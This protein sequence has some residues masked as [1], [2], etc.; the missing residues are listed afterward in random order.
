MHID[1]LRVEEVSP[2]ST[3]H[4]G[5]TWS[6]CSINNLQAEWFGT[7]NATPEVAKVNKQRATV[8]ALFAS[9]KEKK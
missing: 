9:V 4:I 8:N 3:M 5:L 2:V 7:P 1:N 6:P